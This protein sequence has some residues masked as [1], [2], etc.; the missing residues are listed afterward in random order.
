MDTTTAPDVLVITSHL[1]NAR[2]ECRSV[3]R[4]D[5]GGYSKNEQVNGYLQLKLG[6][7][8]DEIRLGKTTIDLM[9]EDDP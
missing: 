8:V 4:L 5:G 1:K 2:N 6:G 9:R 3:G 7:G